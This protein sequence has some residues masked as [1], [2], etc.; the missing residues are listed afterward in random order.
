VGVLV[1]QTD[2]RWKIGDDARAALADAGIGKLEREI[3]FAVRVQAAP[4]HMA[5]TIV[6]EPDSRVGSAYRDVAISLDAALSAT[7]GTPKLQV[8]A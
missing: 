8:V 3:P 5:P 6:L 7:H 1:T 2:R 4:R